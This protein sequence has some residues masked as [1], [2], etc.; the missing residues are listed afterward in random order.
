MAGLE[1]TITMKTGEY[2][3]CI[4]GKEKGLFHRWAEKDQLIFKMSHMMNNKNLDEVRRKYEETYFL[5]YGVTIEKIRSTIGIVE[6][7]D[8]TVKEIKAVN[9]KF[10]DSGN[11]FN[12]NALFY[13]EV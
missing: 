8:G 7:E 9:I 3:P 4:V 2:R 12:E 5:P 13:R 6:F 1:G 11:L 10:L